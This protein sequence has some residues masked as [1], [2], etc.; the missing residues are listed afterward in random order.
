[1]TNI[2]KAKEIKEKVLQGLKLSFD[3]L[4]K[5]KQ[6]RDEEFVFSHEGEVYKVKAR[7]MNSDT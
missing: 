2:E 7:D 4:L 1:M 5:E 6:L 3:K